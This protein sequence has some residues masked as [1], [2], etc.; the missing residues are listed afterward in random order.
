MKRNLVINNVEPATLNLR[1]PLGVNLNLLVAMTYQNGD[2]VDPDLNQ[3]VLAPR[4]RGGV[5]P[6]DMTV[7]DPTNGI[8]QAKI[9]GASLT[10]P[11][12]YNLEIYAREIGEGG[13]P[14]PSALLAKGWIALEGS[15]YNQEGPLNMINVPVVTGPPGPQGP[16]GVR[17]SQWFTGN[18]DPTVSVSDSKVNG[19]MYLDEDTGNVWRYDGVV[20]QQGSF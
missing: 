17:G 18:G 8:S 12:G 16:A 20:W 9:P 1:H 5:Y 13:V 3:L 6:Y 10:D 7:Y 19:D 2:V 4:S 14:V 11:S 15:A